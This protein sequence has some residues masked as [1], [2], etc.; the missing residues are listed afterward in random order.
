MFPI[1]A[2]R[3]KCALRYGSRGALFETEG[4]VMWFIY[5]RRDGG[6]WLADDE[7]SWTSD[8]TEAAS[9]T[10]AA[11]A[12]QIMERETSLS[13]YVFKLEEGS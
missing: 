2:Q 9:F 3:H 8:I 4:L 7:H 10:S 13:G 12:A 5:I 11:I 1:V 6:L